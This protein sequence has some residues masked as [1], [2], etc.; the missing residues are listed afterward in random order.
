MNSRKPLLGA[1]AL[2]ASLL[3]GCGNNNNTITSIP[4]AALTVSVDPAPVPP[5]QNVLTGVVSIGYKIHVT[6]TAGLGGIMQFV[7][8]SVYDPTTGQLLSLTYFDGDDLVVFVGTKRINPGETLTVPQ[9]MSYALP[10]L[11]KNATLVINVQ[12]LDDR[13]NTINQSVLVKVE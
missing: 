8:S 7:S 13:D 4:R 3:S 9:T 11:S 10:D 1:V 5:S 2:A 12:M 6:E